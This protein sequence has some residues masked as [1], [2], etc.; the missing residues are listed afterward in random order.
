MAGRMGN[1][2]VTTRNLQVV[3]TDTER[4]LLYVKGAVP[5]H[6]NGLVRIRPAVSGRA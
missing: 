4:N 6:N 1:E 5:G 3:R 2:R